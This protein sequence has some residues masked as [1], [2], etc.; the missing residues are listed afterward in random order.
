MT[1][2][3]WKVFVDT[4]IIPIKVIEGIVG[5]I[6]QSKVLDSKEKEVYNSHAKIIEG[7]LKNK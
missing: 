4:D 5:K 6:K 2:K 7:L 1:N 3:E